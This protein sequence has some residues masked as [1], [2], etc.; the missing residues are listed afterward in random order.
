MHFR[1]NVDTQ[2]G[3]KMVHI[4]TR[5]DGVLLRDV[6]YDIRALS[7]QLLVRFLLGRLPSI[8]RYLEAVSVV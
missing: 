2:L 8:F 4:S 3:T 7:G 6:T 1:R 5:K